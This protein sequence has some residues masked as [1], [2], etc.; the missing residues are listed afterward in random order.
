[1]RTGKPL[2][3]RYRHSLATVRHVVANSLDA[4]D[5]LAQQ[6]G[7]SAE[8]ISV[9]HNSLVFPPTNAGSASDSR[10][11]VRRQHGASTATFVLLCVAMFRPEKNQRELIEIATRLPSLL[12]WQLWLVGEGPARADCERLAA[13]KNLTSRIKFLGFQPDPS[14]LYA[15]ADVAV[16]ASWSESLSNFLI[17]AQARGVPAVAYDAQG[18]KECFQPGKT[19]WAIAR[20]DREGF[21]SALTRLAALSVVERATMAEMARSCARTRFDPARQA[22]AYFDLFRRL[23]P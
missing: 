9:I 13:T 3:A 10:D 12:D 11:L 20:D 8:K 22:Q 2:P 1:M 7:I 19:G 16:H 6:Y 4:R 14:S 17:E 5:T 23:A 15:A 18:I 21:V